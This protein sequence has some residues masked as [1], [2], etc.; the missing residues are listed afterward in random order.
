MKRKDNLAMI[1]S[2]DNTIVEAVVTE[3]RSYGALVDVGD[4]KGLLHIKEISHYFVS[5][6]NDHL[7]LGKKLKVKVISSDPVN[8]FLKV[9]LKDVPGEKSTKTKTF[10]K[11]NPVQTDFSVLEKTLPTWI[12]K[13]LEEIKNETR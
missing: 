3:I 12:E 11:I 13:A 6:I 4:Q 7:S 9:S 10:E 8:G 1:N 2:K 5:D